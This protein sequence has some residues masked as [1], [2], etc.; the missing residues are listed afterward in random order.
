MKVIHYLSHI[1][2]KY[3]FV[4]DFQRITTDY[5]ETLLYLGREDCHHHLGVVLIKE[6][7]AWKRNQWNGTAGSTARFNGR[8]NNMTITQC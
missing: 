8:H 1:F 5:R 6:G 4:M 2:D 3:I 7:N